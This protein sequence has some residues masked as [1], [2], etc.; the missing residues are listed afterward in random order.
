[1]SNKFSN[2]VS[3]LTLEFNLKKLFCSLLLFAACAAAWA[4]TPA[5]YTL[6][7]TAV[8]MVPARELKREYDIFVSVPTSYRTSTRRY[9]VVFVADAP[10]AFPVVRAIS[11]RV[12]D[13]GKGLEEFII[14]GLGYARGDT[15]HYARRRDYTPTPSTEKGLVSDM[16]GRPL[17]FGEAE[18]FRRYIATEVFPF[19]EKNYRANMGRK[20]FI[21]H[22]YGSLLGLQ[23]L[24]TEPSMFNTYILGSPSLW[25]GN[26][27][28]FAREKAYAAAHKDLR[29]KVYLGVGELEGAKPGKHGYN[30]GDDMVGDMVSDMQ[31]FEKLLKSRRYPGLRIES[32]VFPGDDHFT[33]AP[34]IATRGLKWALPPVK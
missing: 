22:S 6:A 12:G 27:V 14:V 16:P 2:N 19:I 29:A 17:L 5:L 11:K 21:G 3:T 4:Q 8:H 25:Y 33:V 18:G 34:G 30:S 15:A 32:R 9:P 20:V 31:Q 24:F 7:D 10:Y 1:M 13:T 26:R 28:M 23:A